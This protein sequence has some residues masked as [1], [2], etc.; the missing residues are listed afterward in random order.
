MGLVHRHR[1]P[2]RMDQPG[3]DAR[4]HAQALS[5][6]GRIN[7]VSRSDAILWPAMARLAKDRGDRGEPTRVLDIATG[8]GD[9]PIA[10]ARRAIQAG[11]DLRID[12]CDISA[13]AVRFARR[14][15]RRRG[16]A[17]E[18]FSRDVLRDPIPPGYD[19]LTCSLFL[20]H[21]DEAD[22]VALLS[23]MAGA[24]DRLVLINDLLRSRAGYGLAW[25][26][27]RLLS[28][29][30]IVHHDGPVSVAAALTEAEALELARRAGLDGAT[31]TRHWPR[32][33]LLSW[34]HRCP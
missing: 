12:G 27:C 7:R 16:V 28:R 9:V 30:A 23:R 25:V 13:E 24:T 21:L 34:S 22:A 10:L 15:A 3:L 6:L 1:R 33:F 31:L 18:F 20:H 17:V 19:V 8:G 32:R 2:E 29:S 11:L 26:G 5:G 4:E 14:L